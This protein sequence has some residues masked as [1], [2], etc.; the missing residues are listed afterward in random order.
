MV[1]KVVMATGILFLFG[2]V[3]YSE[4]PCGNF[5]VGIAEASLGLVILWATEIV[6][7]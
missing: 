6:T 7:N 5:W 3:G 1:R 2:G 4:A